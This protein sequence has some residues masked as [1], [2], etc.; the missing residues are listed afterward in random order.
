MDPVGLQPS[1]P[2]QADLEHLK[3][4]SVLYYVYAALMMMLPCASLIYVALG[5]FVLKM[6]AEMV[7]QGDH[8]PPALAGW[9]LIAMGSAIFVFGLAL[10]ISV[11]LAGRSLSSRRRYVFCLV[12]AG[13]ICLNMPL[14]TALGAFT[15]AVLLRPSVRVLF[16]RPVSP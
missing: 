5:T 8:P 16:G 7:K 2:S 10:A 4:L 12:V 14:G 11:F 3:V 6:P 15:I 1:Q 9:A 13:V